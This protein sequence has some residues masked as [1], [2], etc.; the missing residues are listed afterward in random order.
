MKSICS[1][2]I[3][4]P[5]LLTITC[6][7]VPF[8]IL[9]A[10][11]SEAQSAQMYRQWATRYSAGAGY[12][13]TSNGVV[14]DDEGSVYIAGMTEDYKNEEEFMVLKY[15]STGEQQWIKTHHGEPAYGDDVATAITIDGD[16]NIYATGTI[17]NSVDTDCL[18]VKYD[19]DGTELW[20]VNYHNGN[21]EQCDG[22]QLDDSGNVYIYGSSGDE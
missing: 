5:L 2:V 13:A 9:I 11:I 12:S 19:A 3:G 7:L 16:G 10:S 8:F 18:T 6:L 15:N 14:V 21:Y 22:V 17:E 20:A 4:M 1:K